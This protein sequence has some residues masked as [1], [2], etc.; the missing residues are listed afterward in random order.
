[1]DTHEELTKNSLTANLE[2]PSLADA[3]TRTPS[4]RESDLYYDRRSVGQSV[5]VSRPPPSGAYDHIFITVRPLRVCGYEAPSLTRGRVCRLQLLLSL[6]A[7]SFSGSSPAGL[8]TTFYC[9]RFETPPTW[10][11]RSLYLY[12]PGTGWPGYTPRHWVTH[13]FLN[14]MSSSLY[15]LVADSI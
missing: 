14:W 8:M 2:L 9:L 3:E 4:W 6:P 10:R 5:L 13:H 1:M 11:T 7:Q 15:S 12:P